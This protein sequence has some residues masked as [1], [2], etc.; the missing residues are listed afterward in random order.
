M[1]M[2]A[3]IVDKA[4]PSPDFLGLTTDEKLAEVDRRAQNRAAGRRPTDNGFFDDPAPGRWAQRREVERFLVVGRTLLIR[5]PWS[6]L[7]ADNEK[8]APALRGKRAVM[9]L[10][11]KYRAGKKKAERLVAEQISSTSLFVG[12]CA[13]QATLFEPN[14]H[15]RRDVTNYAKLVHDAL[16]GRAYLDDSQL[17]DVR[18]IRGPVD[19]DAPR[20]DLSVT[21][22]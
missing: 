7:V 14:R 4:P 11:A 17:Y 3:R 10:T 15:V 8:Y 5:L 21:L 19:V 12:P 2:K 22:R 18:W 1:S 9:I 13:L 20:L 16:I 6:C